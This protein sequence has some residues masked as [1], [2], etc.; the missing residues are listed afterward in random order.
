VDGWQS[1]RNSEDARLAEG[2]DSIEICGSASESLDLPRAF[3]GTKLFRSS[4]RLGSMDRLAPS[5]VR[6][7][8]LTIFELSRWHASSF[9]GLCFS[10]ITCAEHR[11]T[12]L[13]Q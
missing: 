4:L 10:N 6:N 1:T 13:L 7:Q 3:S 2:T 11:G 5:C 8:T 9:S 12:E